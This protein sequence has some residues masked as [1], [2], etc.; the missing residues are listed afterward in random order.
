M[1][2]WISYLLP[3]A[4]LLGLC[5]P[6]GGIL[7]TAE[8]AAQSSGT[9]SWMG[10]ESLRWLRDENLVLTLTGSGEIPDEPSKAGVC[11]FHSV[12][13][14]NDLMS[15]L[16]KIVIGE[17]ITHIGEAFFHDAWSCTEVYLPSTL[18]TIGDYAFDGA[19][20]LQ[21]ISLASVVS[22]GSYAFQDAGLQEID[23]PCSLSY[24]GSY[25]F[26]GCSELTTVYYA[27]TREQWEQIQIEA[28]NSALTNATVIYMAE[29][30]GPSD[31]EDEPLTI[32]TPVLQT[33]K[34]TTKGIAITWNADFYVPGVSLDSLGYQIL[35]KTA[36]GSYETI[37]TLSDLSTDSYTDTDVTMGETYTYTVRIVAGDQVGGYDSQ[38]LTIMR[39]AE[40]L[41]P[42]NYN[43][44]N[45]NLG[46]SVLN[47][48]EALCLPDDYIIPS[49]QF[50]NVL[51]YTPTAAIQNLIHSKFTGYC[52]GMALLA[53]AQY[54][55]QVSLEG[56]FENAAGTLAEFGLSRVVEG[57][58]G[59]LAALDGP[60]LS[61]VEQAFLRQ[62]DPEFENAKVYKTKPLVEPRYYDDLLNYLENDN[63]APLLVNMWSGD[64]KGHTVLTYP[65]VSPIKTDSGLYCIAIY[66]PNVPQ[67]ST[68]LGP[69]TEG[70]HERYLGGTPSYLYLDPDSGKWYYV[71][72]Y[73]SSD[74]KYSNDY[75]VGLDTTINFYDVRKLPASFFRYITSPN[76]SVEAP[77]VL[78][79]ASSELKNGES[80]TVT[81]KDHITL[82][83]L[84]MKNGELE[85][86]L[87]DSYVQSCTP[88][89][90]EGVGLY[91][92]LDED[93]QEL[94]VTGT[95]DAFSAMFLSGDTLYAASAEMAASVT[96]RDGTAAGSTQEKGTLTLAVEQNPRQEN[97]GPT[98]SA[99]TTLAAG[100]SFTLTLSENGVPA[101]SGPDGQKYDVVM[102]EDGVST[103]KNK[104]TEDDLN[105]PAIGA[106]PFTDVTEKDWFYDAVLYTYVNGL[107]SGTS[108]TTFTPNGTMSR[109]MLATV[110]YRME[111]EPAVNYPV[112]QVTYG[113]CEEGKE[114]PEGYCYCGDFQD[115]P[116][117]LWYSDAIM[118]AS[119]QGIVTGYGE[120]TFGT[121]D[122]VTREQMVTMLFRYAQTKTHSFIFQGYG[123]Y[124]DAKQV[125]D[126][127]SEAMMWA[128]GHNMISGTSSS[129]LSPK[130]TATR[131]QCA[132]ILMRCCE[133]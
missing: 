72:Y 2:K 88:I 110:L 116:P 26:S 109:A 112:R 93:C 63:S 60:I 48:R 66:D 64:G 104:V 28:G 52:F 68:C 67:F 9:L 124:K 18:H 43:Y 89:D 80:L 73:E 108:A 51:G 35:R 21:H 37:A 100:K 76:D 119:Q 129:T 107:M 130:A 132:T 57:S 98:V 12:N 120:E 16:T 113:G 23:I 7:P 70:L 62:Y 90:S 81:T 105:G 56:Y 131:A 125:S 114:V 40:I 42:I 77:V 58:Y 127:A 111:G 59:Y 123:N 106:F 30:M 44:K 87:D 83:S 122:P 69:Y 32:P 3:L 118:W 36:G 13:D 115:V 94:T 61:F 102:E 39:L 117:D 78:Q 74:T 54:N 10:N 1:K 11:P 4:L 82:V 27:G 86:F 34:N 97:P 53:A 50:Y 6:A 8:A 92:T 96:F 15:G 95:G 103:E 101:I 71:D 85:V 84:A 65:G 20:D 19:R 22:V 133:D 5:A 126:W 24:I 45:T 91:L 55:G 79:V 41:Y 25:A 14:L 99:E 128:M 38:G 17:G 29:E 33:I 47:S 75:F 121:D 46:W 31:E 49:E